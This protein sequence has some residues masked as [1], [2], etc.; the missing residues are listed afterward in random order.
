V[1]SQKFGPAGFGSKEEKEQLCKK[2]NKQAELGH[3]LY[4]Q[5]RL[6]EAVAIY[7]ALIQREEKSALILGNL[8][9][10]YAQKGKYREAEK[11]LEE[12]ISLDQG[13]SE[14]W[15]T[16][17]FVQKAQANIHGA[18]QAYTISLTLAPNNCYCH[19]N[20]GNA[21]SQVGRFNEAIE[22]YGQALALNSQFPEALT[23]LGSAFL[24]VGEHQ[25][26]VSS[27]VDA[28]SINPS[29]F[30]ALNNLGKAQ[31]A[32]GDSRS[33]IDTFKRAIACNPTSP[34]PF[35]NLGS[36][37]KSINEIKN[38]ADAYQE[39]LRLKPEFAEAHL[40]LGALYAQLG[41]APKAI[42][43][44]EQALIIKPQLVE[45][46]FNLAK[47]YATSNR[48]KEAIIA[49]NKIL[50]ISPKL[51]EVERQLS[52]LVDAKV[53][54]AP[55]QRAQGRLTT[56]DDPG[57]RAR[58]YFA[59]AKY[60]D[61]LDETSA[62]DFYQKGNQE[63]NKTLFWERPNIQQLIKT[64]AAVAETKS[65]WQDGHET[66]FLVGIPC[67][68]A[69]LVQ[70]ILSQNSK[71]GKLG[72]VE[73][74]SM[75][76]NYML[77]SNINSMP[78]DVISSIKAIHHDFDVANPI[79]DHDLFGFQYCSAIARV[80]PRAKIIHCFRNPVDNLLAIYTSYLGTENPW[81][82]DLDAIIDYYDFYRQ[83]MAYHQTSTP[84]AITHLNMDKMQAN[85]WIE[86]PNLIET[87]GLEWSECYQ[88]VEILTQCDKQEGS[89]T[90]FSGLTSKDKSSWLL[91]SKLTDTLSKKLELKG[92]FANNLA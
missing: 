73:F 9:T 56:T 11:L 69:D 7:K 70:L 18:I 59:I 8:A 19:Y 76:S 37:L 74:L 87:C 4:Q 80:F 85:S 46:L 20:L 92:Y 29:H 68:G 14:G 28:L 33:A 84:D 67:C 17:G 65:T 41:S 53:D 34:D 82:Y 57:E 86:I 35:F 79:N 91:R 81:A 47:A 71:L 23:N 54:L 42:A 49:Y 13:F 27:C 63:M 2:T 31:Q 83:I 3:F 24:E 58:L 62:F 12:A 88:N 30:A 72:K 21:L 77:D 51:A 44:Y 52:L 32:L 78:E 66:I 61:D 43:C 1:A 55:M 48:Q 40:N 60:K 6:E 50:L 39:A 15:A 16:L 90:S 36:A 10:I 5:G 38:A 25:K 75:A 26:A 22:A 64:N 89:F 45:A